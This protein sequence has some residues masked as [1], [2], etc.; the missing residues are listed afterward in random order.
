[1]LLVDLHANRRGSSI[2]NTHGATQWAWLVRALVLSSEMHLMAGL[3]SSWK[4]VEISLQDGSVPVIGGVPLP[5]CNI[6]PAVWFK[7][8]LTCS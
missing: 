1:M 3:H 4:C 8:F 7:V 6:E 5:D 2:L